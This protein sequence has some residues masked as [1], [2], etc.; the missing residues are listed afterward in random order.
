[1]FCV[2]SKCYAKTIYVHAIIICSYCRT[3][4]VWLKRDSG[5]YWPSICHTM[6]GLWT[7]YDLKLFTLL[8]F[9]WELYFW[10][11]FLSWRFCSAAVACLDFNTETRRLFV[12]DANGTVTVS[13]CFLPSTKTLKFVWFIYVICAFYYWQEFL[14][15]EDFNHMQHVRDY[16]GALQDMFIVLFTVRFCTRFQSENVYVA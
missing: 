3:I 2:G 9:Y 13:F 12:G 4:R 8:I 14:I 16:L 11:E 5:Q 15:A 6:P 10:V 1:M 7:C